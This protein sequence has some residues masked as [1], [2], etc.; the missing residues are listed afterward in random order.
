MH[1]NNVI[2]FKDYKWQKWHYIG[3]EE[4]PV[5]KGSW[6]RGADPRGGGGPDP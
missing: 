1:S 5:E 4:G 2:W 3:D 6:R